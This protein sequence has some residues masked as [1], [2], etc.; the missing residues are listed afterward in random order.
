MIFIK[1]MTVS[2][3]AV[4]IPSLFTVKKKEQPTNNRQ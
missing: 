4:V 1:L 2:I 3:Y